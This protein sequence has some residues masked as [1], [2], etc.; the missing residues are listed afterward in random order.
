MRLFSEY[1]GLGESFGVPQHEVDALCKAHDEAY[2]DLLQKGEDPYWSYNQ[3]DEDFLRG[4]YQISPA[5]TRENIVQRASLLFAN[6][7]KLLLQHR[8]LGTSLFI[9]QWFAN[10]NF[11]STRSTEM[12]I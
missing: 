9:L 10:L 3:A 4:L 5:S 2:E 1:C 8:G 11:W 12:V 6:G 7:K